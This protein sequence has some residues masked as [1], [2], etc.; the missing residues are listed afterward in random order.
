MHNEYKQTTSQHLFTQDRLLPNARENS[1]SDSCQIIVHLRMR[2]TLNCDVIDMAGEMQRWGTNVPARFL[3]TLAQYL[4]C[5]NYTYL[6]N[7]Q[8]G[9]DKQQVSFRLTFLFTTIIMT[10]KVYI[11][12]NNQ[13]T[14]TKYI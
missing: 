8:L 6:H 12:Y 9:Q 3:L 7:F 13:D 10:T 14:S 1:A 2:V 4:S 11:T 5:P